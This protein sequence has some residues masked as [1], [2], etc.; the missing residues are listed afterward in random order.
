M[1]NLDRIP[2]RP[3]A[4]IEAIRAIGYSFETAIA[5]IVDNA[6]PA[7]STEVDVV[8]H[9]NGP[10]TWCAVVD[11]GFGMTEEELREAM[12]IGSGGAE[13]VRAENDL[14]RFGMG[15]KSAGFSQARRVTVL[16]KRENGPIHV[17]VWDLDVL[18]RQ[19]DW[20][21]L[22]VAS[23]VATEFAQSRLE[24]HGTVVFLEQLDGSLKLN[25]PSQ[26]MQEVQRV[27]SASIVEL[28]NH[29]SRVF[30]R[31]LSR[32]EGTRISVNGVRVEPWLPFVDH[33]ATQEFP[34]E[35]IRVG[36]T[37]IR[38][39]GYVVPHPEMMTDVD[40]IETERYR[41]DL[42]DSQG[43]YL[44]RKDRL[45]IGGTWLDGSSRKELE[46]SL[47][48]IEL[49]IPVELDRH[50]E[51]TVDKT[52][53]S[54]PRSVKPDLLRLSELVRGR[55][56]AVYR[57][58]GA[59][60]PTLTSRGREI[61][62]LLEIG[63]RRGDNYARLNEKHPLVAQ[64]LALPNRD[65]VRTFIGIANE[66]MS[67]LVTKHKPLDMGEQKD[68]TI[69]HEVRKGAELLFRQFAMQ[70]DLTRREI[71]EIMLS[72]EPFVR[73]PSVIDDLLGDLDD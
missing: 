3:D 64:L 28:V 12:R 66:A 69:P 25:D 27:V 19:G 6:V 2:P 40:A 53:F 10:E 70:P 5:D 24:G 11:N 34:I 13:R 41:R 9:A 50:W 20:D 44:Y 46:T 1:S 47:A 67:Q 49:D 58:R 63:T 73:Y 59:T 36:G 55:S 32:S 26:S 54:P 17:R 65:L 42:F 72:I 45:I 52:R 35:D 68:Q 15:L 30:G 16:S 21:A 4:T 38:C 57:S 39:R 8:V 7:A 29:L 62:P 23:K 22:K 33:P 56:R 43:F 18:R 37:S 61:V 60:R 48:R 31:F 14:G 71:R 51:L